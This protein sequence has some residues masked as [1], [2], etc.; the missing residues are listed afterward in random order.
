MGS[1]LYRGT[2]T[3]YRRSRR[4]VIFLL[5]SALVL[6]KTYQVT[7]SNRTLPAAIATRRLQGFSMLGWLHHSIFLW[8]HSTHESSNVIITLTTQESWIS[9]DAG[10]RKLAPFTKQCQDN[11]DCGP[12]SLA[13]ISFQMLVTSPNLQYSVRSLADLPTRHYCTYKAVRLQTELRVREEYVVSYYT[14]TGHYPTYLSY[15]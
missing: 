14:G 10:V 9:S 12:T 13:P 4:D 3:E 8:Y 5:W 11:N 6:T 2:R 1:N 7:K 15:W